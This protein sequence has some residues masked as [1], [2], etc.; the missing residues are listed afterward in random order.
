MTLRR[1]IRAAAS[2]RPV[3]WAVSA[4]ERLDRGRAD[5]LAVLTY[6]RI[7]EPAVAGMHAALYVSPSDF[8]EQLDVLK[9]RYAIVSADDVLDARHG[10][11][12]LPRH[13]LLLTFDDAY[14]DFGATAWPRLRERSLPAL[15]FVPTSYP[16]QPHRWFWWDRLGELLG[17]APSAASVTTP[18]G[19][20][21]GRHSPGARARLPSP[22]RSLQAHRRRCG[23]RSRRRPRGRAGAQPCPERGPRLGRPPPAGRRGSRDRPALPDSP[24]PADAL[25]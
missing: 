8:E 21:P 5:V 20:P 14:T 23:L 9:R 2:T 24:P 6:H 25:R 12:P 16:D 13:A 11:R 17:R 22:A 7:A 19:E 10:R 15:L 3:E 4:L 1:T 18:L